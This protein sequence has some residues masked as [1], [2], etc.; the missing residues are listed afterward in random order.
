M[1]IVNVTPDSFSDGGVYFDTDKAIA[2]GL[3][4]EQAGADIID[5]GA[6]STRPG[7]SPVGAREQL[8][9]VEPVVAALAKKLKIPVS[10]D[11][12]NS[13]VARRC[14][15]LGASIINDIYALRSDVR[16]GPVI[17]RYKAGVVLMHMRA[18]PRR[19]QK[20][21]HYRE[22]T[23]EVLGFLKQ[24]KERALACGI[25]AD[26]IALD[27]GI[28]FGKTTEHNLRLMRT[29]SRLR[30]LGQPLL[31]GTSRKSFIG[32]VL[33]A[34]VSGREF[35]TAVSVAYA[36]LAGASILRV[37]NVRQMRE[38]TEMIRAID[39]VKE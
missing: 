21:P 16:L 17:A 6:E 9:R 36:A 34:P 14:L 12:G 10:I 19:M 27:P 18:N 24:A 15:E 5:I 20:D 7:A 8:R 35:G 2:H 28:G 22:V 32:N 30:I 31:V 25:G 37:H 33:G 4:L 1:G 11:T 23:A 13:I 26:R 29:L 39:T 38:V 3:E